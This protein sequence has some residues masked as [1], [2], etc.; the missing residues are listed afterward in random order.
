MFNQEL[1][2]R[3]VKEHSTSLYKRRCCV[4]VF[5]T[6]APYEEKLGKDVCTMTSDEIEPVA[7]DLLG[8]RQKS[9]MRF[10]ILKKYV[11]WC[12]ANN[13]NGA[14]DELDKVTLS[15]LDKLKRRT[16]TG[17]LQLQ[18]Y[19]NAAFSPESSM[20]IDNT[21]RAFFW[22][23]FAGIPFD[24]SLD[25][26]TDQVDLTGMR[27]VLD[28]REYP[29]YKE[30]LACFRNCVESQ[31]FV[32]KHPRYG[33]PMKCSRVDGDLLFRGIRANPVKTTFIPTVRKLAET[34]RAE[35]RTDK[36]LSYSRIKMSGQFYRMYEDERAGLPVD[37][38]SVVDEIISEKP[39]A[40]YSRMQRL[41]MI[42][43][44]IGDY[45]NWKQTF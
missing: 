3:F 5:N 32:R 43:E 34:A 21:Y 18:V 36:E 35:G 20:G 6:I 10:D 25:I 33:T 7:N 39:D 38:G 42:R 12:V 17:P 16:V 41:R 15:N 40:Y 45:E 8:M 2:Q 22:L 1:K 9:T 4:D 13:V 14:V 28:G 30:G 29:I 31:F 44:L 11:E 26:T 37:A 24:S 23:A 27:I 19:L